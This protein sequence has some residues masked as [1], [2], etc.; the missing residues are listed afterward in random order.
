M[1]TRFSLSMENEQADTGRNGRTRLA[2]PNSQARTRTEK[3]DFPC[4]ADHEQ[5]WQPH[6]VGPFFCYM[7]DHTYIPYMVITCSKSM[8][9]IC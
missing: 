6:Q 5:D 3:Y 8:D 9:G 7:C 4:S 2:R 1:S